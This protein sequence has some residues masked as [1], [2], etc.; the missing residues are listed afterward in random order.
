MEPARDLFDIT[1]QLPDI[2]A[3]WFAQ[4]GWQPRAHQLALLEKAQAGRSTLLIAPTGGGKT[5]AGF[6]P[7]LIELWEQALPRTQRA[8]SPLV[9]EGWGGGSSA[10]AQLPPT[11]RASRVDLPHKGGGIGEVVLR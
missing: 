3:R 11:R 1:P 5:L 7:T 2:F 9:G 4:R 8:P 6:L 10:L